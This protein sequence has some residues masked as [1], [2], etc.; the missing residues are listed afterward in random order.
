MSAFRWELFWKTRAEQF[1]VSE[2]TFLRRNASPAQ[3][4]QDTD[5]KRV[6]LD[7][8]STSC[9]CFACFSTLKIYATGSS[10]TSADFRSTT[11]RYLISYTEDFISIFPQQGPEHTKHTYCRHSLLPAHIRNK[12]ARFSRGVL[13]LPW[14]NCPLPL[15]AL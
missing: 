7:A 10:E 15:T 8:Y 9:S 6:A 5:A 14:R 4:E 13:T 3:A 1:V 2:T 12:R 11:G